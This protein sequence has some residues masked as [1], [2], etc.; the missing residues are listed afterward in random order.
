[1][2][3]L[4]P[5]GLLGSMLEIE[6]LSG[7]EGELAGFLVEQMQAT[8]FEAFRDEAGNA[9]GIKAGPPD[10]RGEWSDLVLLGHMDTVPGKLQVRRQGQRLYGRG[11]VDAKG[12]LATFI[13]AVG[14]SL[15]PPGVRYI[16]IGAVEEECASSRGARYVATR[17]QPQACIIG[18]PSGWQGIT[19]GYKGRLVVDVQFE[20]DAGHSAGPDGTAGETGVAFWLAVGQHCDQF[21]NGHRRLFDQ[22]LPTLQGF[23]TTSDGLRELAELTVGF[24]LPPG[25]DTPGLEAYLKQ[26][27]NGGTLIAKGHES[28]YQSSRTSPLARG[29]ARSV[30][31]AG[32]RPSFQV[33]TGTSDMNVVGPAWDCPIVAYGPGDSSLDHTPDEHILIPEYLRAIEVLKN[34]L[35]Y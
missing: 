7:Q 26:L 23:N 21:N 28:A 8:G 27:V 15:P 18:E 5:V 31:R 2:S 12:P 25:F 35:G 3:S 29:L 33:K 6:S 16:L 14:D 10:P 17:Y 4:E 34:W 19:L 20:Q 32:G 11:A 24:R 22:L 13:C 9:V 30:M 1:M